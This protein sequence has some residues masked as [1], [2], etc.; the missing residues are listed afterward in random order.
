VRLT[1]PCRVP[2]WTA[3][4]GKEIDFL[5]INPR[6]PC[7]N[8]TDQYQAPSRRLWVLPGQSETR[9]RESAINARG[10]N[11]KIIGKTEL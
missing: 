2:A 8:D 5:F 7:P 4:E 10:F 3:R 6:T 9:V 11:F 1:E